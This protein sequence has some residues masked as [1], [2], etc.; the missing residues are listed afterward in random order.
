MSMLTHK[1]GYI[2]TYLDKID[3]TEGDTANASFKLLL[4]NHHTNG[5]NK[6]KTRVNLPV[7]LVLVFCKTV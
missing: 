1:D 3:E 2:S 4:T 5:D 7:D 6:S